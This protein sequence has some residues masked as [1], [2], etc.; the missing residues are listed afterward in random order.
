MVKIQ[1][2]SHKEFGDIRYV[3]DGSIWIVAKDIILALGYKWDEIERRKQ[4]ELVAKQ[5]QSR[6]NAVEEAIGIAGQWQQVKAMDWVCSIFDT[7]GKSN[8]VWSK[9]GKKATS[10]SYELGYDI[11]KALDSEWG[12]VNVYHVDVLKALYHFVINNRNFLSAYRK[13]KYIEE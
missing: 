7:Y 2:I 9:L 12:S 3:N 5:A 10:L 1:T 8:P 6:A 4:A 13:Q 11:R